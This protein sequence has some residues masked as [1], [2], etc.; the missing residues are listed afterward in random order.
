MFEVTNNRRNT[1]NALLDEEETQF[2]TLQKTN[3]VCLT[4]S[5]VDVSVDRHL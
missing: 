4:V 3:S 1:Q 5:S 2:M